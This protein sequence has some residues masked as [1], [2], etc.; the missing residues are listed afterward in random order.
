TLQEKAGENADIIWGNGYDEKLG[1]KISVT[2]LA[3]GFITNPNRELQPKKEPE[4]FDLIEEKPEPVNVD[5][6]FDDPF[7]NS[8]EKPEEVVQE[9]EEEPEMEETVMYVQPKEQVAKKSGI[10]LN[11]GSKKSKPKP[12]PKPKVE[13]KEELL[14]ESSVDDWFVNKFKLNNIFN[15]DDVQ[16]DKLE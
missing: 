11:W 6:A 5:N 1:D 14:K 8:E 3:T 10:K 2:I 16:D 9:T 4:K 12:K 13:K 15:D 7:F